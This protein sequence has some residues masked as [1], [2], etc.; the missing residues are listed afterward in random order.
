M[1]MDQIKKWGLGQWRRNKRWY[2]LALALV[3]LIYDDIDL[4][5]HARLLTRV[6]TIQEQWCEGLGRVNKVCEK[7][8]ADLA[9]R[10]GL[11]TDFMPLVTT[12]IWNRAVPKISV[13]RARRKLGA[14]EVSRGVLDSHRVGIGGPSEADEPKR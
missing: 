8:M 13:T 12:A 5:L 6:V 10:L 11:D 4:R 7:T 3:V 14:S 2:L 9:A 1:L